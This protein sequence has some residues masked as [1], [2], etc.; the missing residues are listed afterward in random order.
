MRFLVGRVTGADILGLSVTH[1]PTGSTSAK[2]NERSFSARDVEEL[3][4]DGIS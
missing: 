1:P 2:Y 3:S 4:G